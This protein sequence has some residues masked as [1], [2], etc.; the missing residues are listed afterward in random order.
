MDTEN[1]NPSLAER[2]KISL[3]KAVENGYT[4]IVDASPTKVVFDLASF[5]SEFETQSKRVLREHI[6]TWQEE[7]KRGN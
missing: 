7:K 3:D 1:A 2:V 6:K 5:C 4:W